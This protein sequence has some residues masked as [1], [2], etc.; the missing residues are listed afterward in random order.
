MSEWGYGKWWLVRRCHHMSCFHKRS[1]RLQEWL[2]AWDKERRP[3]A[4]TRLGCSL[5]ELPLKLSSGQSK[6]RR[7]TSVLSAGV[8]RDHI[9][10]TV[11]WGWTKNY[12]MRKRKNHHSKNKRTLVTAY[13]IL[14]KQNICT[15]VDVAV[16]S[17]DNCDQQWLLLG[18]NTTI[19]LAYFT[20]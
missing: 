19:V 17:E 15:T 1:G 5:G 14:Q 18:D 13:I 4:L 7:N 12:D 16:S 8:A 9:A 20:L 11:L 6:P 10:S 3:T 2:T